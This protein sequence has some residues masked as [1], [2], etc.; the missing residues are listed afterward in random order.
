[1]EP[2][3]VGDDAGVRRLH[4]RDVA[5][6]RVRTDDDHRH[7]RAHAVGAVGVGLEHRRID[8]VR[9]SAPVVEGDEHHHVVPQGAAV[10]RPAVRHLEHLLVEPLLGCG[11]AAA[12]AGVEVASRRAE[13][14]ADVGERSARRVGGELGVGAHVGVH[15][16]VGVVREG[17][18]GAVVGPRPPRS[19]EADHHPRPGE[20]GCG[21]AV[22]VARRPARVGAD[23]EGVVGEGVGADVGEVAVADGVR[24]HEAV[25]QRQLR[26]GVA[27]AH[28]AAGA[29]QPGLPV[30][31]LVGMRVR[32]LRERGVAVEPGDVA[33]EVVRGVVL[34][35]EDDEL[36]RLSCGG[37]HATPSWGCDRRRS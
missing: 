27:L 30:V 12:R 23:R 3:L 16:R 4:V 24:V 11:H 34:H 14:V 35:E 20:E 18:A 15:G 13:D 29:V 10:L 33:A 25:E 7:P 21:A 17:E 22:R 26:A 2:L 36:R 1:M 9:P 37:G 6:F 8:V 31:R 5:R 32:G 28:R 19:V